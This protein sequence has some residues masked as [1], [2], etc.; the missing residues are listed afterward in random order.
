MSELK[1]MKCVI[2]L[3]LSIVFSALHNSLSA[4]RYNIKNYTTRD[5]LSGQ[6]VNGVFQD[7]SGYLW[8]A[9]QSGVCY[10]NGRTFIP[11]QPTSGIQG[12]DAV[13]VN[14]D[15]EGRIWIGT[16]ANGLYIYDYK[17]L[18][19]YNESTGFISNVVRSVFVDNAKTMWVLTSKGVVKYINGKFVTV[20]DSKGILKKGVLSMTQAKDGSFWFGTQGNGLVKLSGEKFT[21]FTTENGLLDEYV[22]SLNTF[23]DSLLIGTTSQGLQSFYHDTFSHV[24]IPEIENAWISNVITTKHNFTIVSSSGLIRYSSPSNYEVIT[25]KNG[26]SSND[27]YYGLKDRENN[28]WIT[29]GNGVTCLRNEEI[30]SFDEKSGL[31]DDKITCIA[32]LSD[33]RLVIGTYGFGLNILSQDGKVNKQIVHPQLMKVKITAIAEIPDR[34]ELWIGAETSN[35]GIVVLD[36]KNNSFKVKRTIPKI[37]GLE[38]QTVTKIAQDK[39]KNIWVGT[40]NA[41]LFKISDT[42]TLSYRKSNLL[43]SNEVYTFHID[44]HGMP[45]VSIFQK[46]IYKFNGSSFESIS[47]KYKLLD[48]FTLSIDEDQNGNL[49][50]GNKTEGLTIIEPKGV[51]RINVKSGLLS[52]TIESVFCDQ[53]TI[54]IGTDRGLNKL[55]LSDDF[56]ILKIESYNE[57]SGLLNSEIQQNALLITKNHVWIGS[58]GGLSRLTKNSSNRSYVKPVLEISSIK[59]FYD[60]VEWKQKATSLNQ[61]GIPTSLDLGH[62]DN[63]LTFNFNALTT[64]QV[65]YSYILVGQDENWTTYSDKNEVTYTNI[66]PGSY[67]FKVKAINNLGVESAIMQIPVVIRSP[68]WQTW[69]FRILVAVIIFLIIIFYIRYRE[70]RYKV[71]RAKLESMVEE[72]TKEAVFATERAENQ[73]L[74]V[75]QKN[76]EILDS[77][78]YAKRIQTAML[79]SIDDLNQCFN[80]LTVLYKPKD[81]VAGDFYWFEET[82]HYKMIAV[83]D[84]TGHGVPGAI[85][86]V[87]CYNALNRS[88]REYGLTDPGKILNKTREI[89]LSELSKHDEN[90][91]DGMDISLVVL[92]NDGMQMTWAG[93]NNPLWILRASN[94]ELVEIKAD[95]QPIGMHINNND[96]TTHSI[97]L[98]KDD[99]FIIFTDGYSD[100]FGGAEGKKFK[101]ANLKRLLQDNYQKSVPELGIILNETFET[102]MKDEEQIDDVC[103]LIFKI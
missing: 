41:G 103:L 89:I 101:S 55:V 77:I 24:D 33:G 49:Y 10:F 15:E 20:T 59:L 45:W 56:K 40:F 94:A 93:A 95:K 16:N 46:G 92:S 98:E 17:K 9:T 7:K 8:F 70:N 82:E 37:K 11:F 91:K 58:S 4:Q 18:K 25:E 75:E 36:T 47:E 39:K 34:N 66:A 28:V 53:Q 26:L 52:N 51:H 2:A 44:R 86:S 100:Q 30:L 13:I 102:W 61:W 69:W 31:S 6:I 38:L 57:K 87:V 35:E 88:V 67:V 29:S 19:N 23:G 63:H 43:P 78:S 21:Y 90:V 84:C 1:N 54:W 83:A 81:I 73:K 74:L 32:K 65:L 68:Y 64:S 3:L 62:K 14:Q 48:R 5:G 42:D 97:D 85:V 72:R 76:K 79:P 71:Q 96:Y 27:L 80:Q 60:E 99:F 12:V 50:F 22:F